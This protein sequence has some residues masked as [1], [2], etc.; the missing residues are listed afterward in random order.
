[1]KGY[2]RWIRRNPETEP[3]NVDVRKLDTLLSS[4]HAKPAGDTETEH[5]L[6]TRRAVAGKPNAGRGVSRL[7]DS[8]A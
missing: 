2:P 3:Q 4:L 1:M 7:S 6:T 8:E 5:F